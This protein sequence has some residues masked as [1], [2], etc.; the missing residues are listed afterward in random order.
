MEQEQKEKS[1]GCLYYGCLICLVLVVLVVGIA[2]LGLYKLR[3]TALEYTDTVPLELAQVTMDYGEREALN[4]KLDA[5]AE[6]VRQGQESV[7][8][9][10]TDREVNALINENPDWQAFD[11][12]LLVQFEDGK[13]AG[14]VSLPLDALPLKL[15]K[16]RYLNGSGVFNVFMRNGVLIVNLEE[17]TVKGK[18]I[19]EPIMAE[20]E[21]VNLAQDAYEDV[22][23]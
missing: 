8:L 14:A 18:Q 12:R 7:E 15:A 11:G 5:F 16:G 4:Q 19:P 2:G 10:L 22:L 9:I 1:R 23:R 6:T 17:L 13:V 20:L 3:N 21:N